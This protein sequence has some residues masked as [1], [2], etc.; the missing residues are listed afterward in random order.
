MKNLKRFEGRKVKSLDKETKEEILKNFAG[1]YRFDESEILEA[2]ITSWEDFVNNC[3]IVD[4]SEDEQYWY[5]FV[6]NNTQHWI[7]AS[8]CV[9]EIDVFDGYDAQYELAEESD[10]LAIV[11][12]GDCP[13][14]IYD[15]DNEDYGKMYC[16]FSDIQEIDYLWGKAELSGDCQD[17]KSAFALAKDLAKEAG[18]EVYV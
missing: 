9:V 14:L 4:G 8:V 10:T 18:E 16:V 3:S 11:E 15:A 13:K 2:E 17:K 6:F 5:N 12:W 1:S 7:S